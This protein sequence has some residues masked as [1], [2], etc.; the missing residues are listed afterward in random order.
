MD[1]GVIGLWGALLSPKASHQGE[2]IWTKTKPTC[3][4]YFLAV[5][6]KFRSL[7]RRKDFLAPSLPFPSS[8]AP[9][10][11]DSRVRGCF[12]GLGCHTKWRNKGVR[13]ATKQRK[14]PAAYPHLLDT[15]WDSRRALWSAR[16]HFPPE[17]S[18]RPPT[19]P[20][21]AWALQPSTAL[22]STQPAPTSPLLLPSPS[23]QSP[24]L[25]YSTHLASQFEMKAP[26]PQATHA[27]S[28]AFCS[29]V[30]AGPSVVLGRLSLLFLHLCLCSPP[31][32]ARTV[33][34]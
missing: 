3:Y 31:E 18:S 22:T 7:S 10:T 9:K 29:P 23:H 16:H 13:G 28:C 25:E 21:T 14:P 19:S 30:S 20:F 34:T 32:A 24:A 27:S 2:G 11:L 15:Q 33:I 6:W 12:A 26:L 17:E 8:A 1:S 5:H 4:K